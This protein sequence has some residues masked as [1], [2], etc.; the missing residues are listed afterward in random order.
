MWYELIVMDLEPRIQVVS[1]LALHTA[2]T[3]GQTKG[4]KE[5]TFSNYRSEKQLPQ[6]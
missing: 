5:Y 3:E 4:K 1:F 2:I 6:G